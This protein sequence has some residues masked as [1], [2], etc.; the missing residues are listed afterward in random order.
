MK[1]VVFGASGRTGREVVRQAA[2][3]GHSV[4][5]VTRR[6]ADYDAPAG[7]D[8]RTANV[9]EP[10]SLRGLLLGTDAVISAVGPDDGRRATTVYSAGAAAITAEMRRVGAGRLVVLSAVPVSADEEKTWFERLVL[11]PML[12]RFF[13]AS[14]RDLRAMEFTL[15]TAEDL[16]W[17]VVRPPRLTDKPPRGSVRAAWNAPLRGARMISRRALA[18]VLL[19]VATARPFH[20]GVLTVSE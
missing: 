17:A 15:T 16:E 4:I 7:V 20:G 18:R 3:A 14:Y 10:D 12:W 6:P 8:V 1:I 5:A 11:H 9:L 19:E 2:A 13:G